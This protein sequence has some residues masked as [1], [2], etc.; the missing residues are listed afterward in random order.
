MIRSLS[1]FSQHLLR[2]SVPNRAG[3]VCHLFDAPLRSKRPGA[4]KAEPA[5]HLIRRG[6]VLVIHKQ[7]HMR[8]H[9]RLNPHLLHP[10]M[11]G[12]PASTHR[13]DSQ[14]LVCAGASRRAM[15]FALCRFG[16]GPSTETTYTSAVRRTRPFH[17]TRPRLCKWVAEGKAAGR[18][19][20]AWVSQ[21]AGAQGSTL[22][23]S[24]KTGYDR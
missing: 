23:S 5:P 24:G 20:G 17:S 21:M 1:A 13:T 2:A 9:L 12:S 14:F 7:T 15:S 6:T 22:L 16:R 3:R 8:F 4:D 18:W 11:D 19:E 10:L